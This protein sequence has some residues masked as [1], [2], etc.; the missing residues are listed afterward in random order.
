MD[1]RT[2]TAA[3][4]D[5]ASVVVFVVIGR[6][7]HDQ[8]GALAGIAST[9]TPFLIGLVIA[10]LA[11]RAW[12]RPQAILTG[13]VIWPI[14]LLVGMIVRRAVFDDGTAPAFVVVATLFVGMCL[15][16]WRV[17]ARS[18]GAGRRDQPSIDSST[19]R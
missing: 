4:L 12:K 13:V 10:W 7:E 17:V 11:A 3:A 14:T 19:A 9:A 16:G 2:L 15:V 18:V 5:V 6:R 8:S 1:R